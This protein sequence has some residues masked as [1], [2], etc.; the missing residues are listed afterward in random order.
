MRS[1]SRRPEVPQNSKLRSE[2]RWNMHPR[3]SSDDDPSVSVG[4]MGYVL[5]EHLFDEE[6]CKGKI[7][8]TMVNTKSTFHLCF[9]TDSDKEHLATNELIELI[10]SRLSSDDD[11]SVSVGA[12][13]YV[14]VEHLF[15]EEWC[16][17]KIVNTMVNTKSTFHLCFY[18]DSDKE[19]L[20]T[21]ELIELK[22]RATHE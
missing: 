12:M 11:P 13:G 6:W 15:D 17:G 8:N 1:G 9:Y 22:A 19:H 16:K 3:L 10:S 18:T 14:L 5:V 4:A 7:V 2:F 20:A 21:N